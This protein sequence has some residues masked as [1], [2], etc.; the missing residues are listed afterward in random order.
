M[1]KVA[2]RRCSSVVNVRTVSLDKNFNRQ[3][4]GLLLLANPRDF[5][6]PPA[7]GHTMQ[8]HFAKQ[9]LV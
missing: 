3:F 6:S 5:L 2:E 4:W 1:K 9:T 7:F 8:I